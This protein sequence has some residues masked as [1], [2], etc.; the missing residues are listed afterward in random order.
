VFHSLKAAEAP[1]PE[2]FAR[3]ALVADHACYLTKE[4]RADFLRLRAA[5]FGFP[6]GFRLYYM[7]D[8]PV[9]YTG[10]YPVAADIFDRLHD[11]PR[12]LKHRGD[13][14]PARDGTHI[15]LFNYS[16]APAFRKTA[17]SRTMM[18]DYAA[19]VRSLDCKGLAAVTVS[20]DGVRV[21]ERFGLR[22]RGDMTHDGAPE[23]VYALRL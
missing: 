21:A 1:D 4:D 5:I 20:E 19:A 15:Y 6:E 13:M 11:T 7:G 12:T 17:Y 8:A 14:M 3:A 2:E 22:Y 18:Q 23:G 9:G 16:I 10:L